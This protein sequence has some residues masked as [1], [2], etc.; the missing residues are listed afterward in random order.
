MT[1]SSSGGQVV[2]GL[3]LGALLQPVAWLIAWPHLQVYGLLAFLWFGT[4]QSIAILPTAILFTVFG[5][6]GVSRGLLYF[7]AALALIN[8]FVWAGN[9]WIFH[10]VS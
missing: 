7:G 5:K 10:S 3:V 6:R 2:A 1:S 8:L 4:V 9:S